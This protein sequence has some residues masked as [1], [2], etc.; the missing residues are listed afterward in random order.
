MCERRHVG[1]GLTPGAWRVSTIRVHGCV[2]AIAV[3]SVEPCVNRSRNVQQL[4]ALTLFGGCMND[5]W[6]S[7]WF[8]G[9]YTLATGILRIWTFPL[10][11]R[12]EQTPQL[13]PLAPATNQE[14]TKQELMAPQSLKFRDRKSLA[15]AKRRSK[16]RPK[17]IHVSRRSVGPSKVPART[18]KKGR[19]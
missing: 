1:R 4:V 3:W 15:V 10:A 9:P 5:S 7:L 16:R 19:R 13:L 17:K 12:P 2:T 14:S 18:G 8:R 6:L 11:N